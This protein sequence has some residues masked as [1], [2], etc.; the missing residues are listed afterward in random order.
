M[1]LRE[2]GNIDG[3]DTG[4]VKSQIEL[5]MRLHAAE[6][7]LNKSERFL[8]DKTDENKRLKEENNRLTSK[9]FPFI[10]LPPHYGK[11]YFCYTLPR[12]ASVYFHNTMSF[13][14]RL[15]T[16]SFQGHIKIFKVEFIYKKTDE[17]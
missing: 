1:L 12:E 3:L 5:E 13:F 16:H 6:E 15:K 9:Q 2:L 11:H 7:A 14:K 17:L 10:S 4:A 8:A